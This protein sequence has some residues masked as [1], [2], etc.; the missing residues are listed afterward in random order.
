MTQDK[1]MSNQDFI[2]YIIVTPIEEIV[3][4][5]SVEFTGSDEKTRAKSLTNFICLRGMFQRGAQIFSADDNSVIVSYM[6]SCIHQ[7]QE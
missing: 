1:P 3:E 6:K 2:R 7:K 4:S 5:P